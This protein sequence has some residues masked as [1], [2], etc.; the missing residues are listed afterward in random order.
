MSTTLKKTKTKPISEAYGECNTVLLMSVEF[1][2]YSKDFYCLVNDTYRKYV[3]P[4]SIPTITSQRK[5]KSEGT[6]T[7]PSL[8]ADQ[9]SVTPFTR[10]IF[11]F[12]YDDTAM[13]Q[14]INN[15]I[16]AVNTRALPDIQ[17]SNCSSVPSSITI[18]CR[19]QCVPMRLAIAKFN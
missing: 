18:M 12:K 5:L 11:V 17:V 1:H 14:A 9:L 2:R 4:E 3:H 8:L 13:L 6:N 10:M 15:A 7:I 16:N 19:E